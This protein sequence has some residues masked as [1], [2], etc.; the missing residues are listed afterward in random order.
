MYRRR[1]YLFEA[2]YFSCVHY[3]EVLFFV[4]ACTNLY[5]LKWLRNMTVISFGYMILFSSAPF[6]IIQCI[7]VDIILS[8]HMIFFSRSKAECTE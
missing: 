2:R 1:L 3:F 6:N 4:F 7:V 5:T 8:M